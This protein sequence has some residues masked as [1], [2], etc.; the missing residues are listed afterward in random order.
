M[1]IITLISDWHNDDFYTASVKGLLYSKCANVRV[2]DIS[3]KIDT[4]KY[5]QA[6]FVL[7]NAF[8]HFP[9]GTI[10]IV[11]INSNPDEAHP[12]ICLKI[13]GHYFLGVA[14][15]IFSLMF[16]EKPEKVVQIEESG[17][18]KRS[19]FS[20]LTLFSQAAIALVNGK[21]IDDLGPELPGKYRHV[22]FLPA[23]DDNF[24]TGS[25][26]YIDSYQNAF[27][28]ITR[29]LFNSVGKNRKFVIS[30]K[31]DSFSTT[32][33]SNGYDDVESG[34]ILAIFN[35][36]DLLEIAQRDGKLAELFGIQLNSPITV[37]F[38]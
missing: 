18:I 29:E 11:G 5:T 36:L 32:K 13:K 30:F 27:T 4:F 3:H 16:S 14:S 8:L 24:I 21:S 10:H 23:I 34:E 25:M 33:I 31:S 9:E 17:D 15:G 12:P 37:R 38:L 26:I 22:Q 6:A 7:R 19:T 2:V 35:S 28:N 20:E 1:Q